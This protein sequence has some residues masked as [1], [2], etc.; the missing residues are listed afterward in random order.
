MPLYPLSTAPATLLN[1]YDDIFSGVGS[2]AGDIV[3]K[4][5]FGTFSPVG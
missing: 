1:R 3:G 2:G 4:M 5:S